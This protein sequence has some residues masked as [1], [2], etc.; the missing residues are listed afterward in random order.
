MT[1]LPEE[2]QPPSSGVV[3]HG[4]ES[5]DT[6]ARVVHRLWRV[7]RYINTFF[8][9][10]RSAGI[11]AFAAGAVICAAL[12]L[13]A[14][15][16]DEGATTA[17]TVTTGAARTAAPK[18]APQPAPATTSAPSRPST[19][20]RERTDRAPRSASSASGSGGSVPIRVPAGF[21]IF[22]GRITPPEIRVPAFLTIGLSLGTYDRAAY[23]VRIEL[24]HPLTLSVPKRGLV[25]RR[26][27]GLPAGR[28]ALRLLG[29][30]GH[31]VLV[32]GGEPGP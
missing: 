4:C 1:A 2:P 21:L 23:R 11:E 8:I 3:D 9:G 17:S 6:G 27:P 31:A 26:V 5:R 7:S 22:H 18:P 12:A 28:Y 25:T 30:R 15:G 29:R 14:C 19:T 32:V 20:P 24:P 10:I 13:S 16:D